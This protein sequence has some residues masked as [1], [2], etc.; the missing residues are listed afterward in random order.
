MILLS[1][2]LSFLHRLIV[3]LSPSVIYKAAKENDSNHR[4]NYDKPNEIPIARTVMVMS[5]MV[6]VV[7]VMHVPSLVSA[8]HFFKLTALCSS[9]LNSQFD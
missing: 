6:I 8:L 9:L 5:Q 7:V 4:H 3:N 1:T 2:I